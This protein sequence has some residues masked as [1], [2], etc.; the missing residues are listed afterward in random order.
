MLLKEITE[1]LFFQSLR[2]GE[3]I[4]FNCQLLAWVVF[5]TDS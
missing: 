3:L 1:P 2:K 4:T 5:L